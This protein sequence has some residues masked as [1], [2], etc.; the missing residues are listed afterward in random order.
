M[1]RIKLGI[2]CNQ[3]HNGHQHTSS[4]YKSKNEDSLYNPL[5]TTIAQPS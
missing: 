5:L 2:S 4:E 1:S 3:Y